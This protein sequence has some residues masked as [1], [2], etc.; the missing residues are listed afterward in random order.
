MINLAQKLFKGAT[1]S[2]NG[3]PGIVP[4]SPSNG[5]NT[6]FLRADGSWEIPAGG[7]SGACLVVTASSISSLPT[8]ISDASITATM[9]CIKAE[10]SN[11]AAQVNDW[12]VTTV[13]GTATVSG[14]ISGT[15]NIKLYLMGSV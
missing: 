12:T 9:V 6:K 2:A 3:Q 4:E 7:G 13:S 5:Y 10:L 11:P 1:S 14:S 8:T 15:T